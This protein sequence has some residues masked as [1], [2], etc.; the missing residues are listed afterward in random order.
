MQQ[1]SRYFCPECRRQFAKPG[2]DIQP[3]NGTHCPACGGQYLTLVQ[4]TPAFP[5]ADYDPTGADVPRVPV[6]DPPAAPPNMALLL[7]EAEAGR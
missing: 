3:F 4:Y 6:P 5:G 1:Q 2:S 7:T